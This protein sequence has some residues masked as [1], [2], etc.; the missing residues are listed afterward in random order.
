[1]TVA[2]TYGIGQVLSVVFRLLTARGPSR[3]LAGNVTRHRVL[4]VGGAAWELLRFFTLLNI[5][6]LGVLNL[7]SLENV[8]DMA[9]FGAP[10]LVLAAVFA[11]T[12]VYPERLWSYIPLLRLGKLLA[13]LSGAAAMLGGGFA[14]ALLDPPWSA[15]SAVSL[16]GTL[17]VDFILLVVLL[18]YPRNSRSS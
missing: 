3:T 8:V 2:G 12:A 17:L 18:L 7:Q 5:L 11:V 9:W 13:V 4:F 6:S 1:M 15:V 14:P 10:Q 16:L